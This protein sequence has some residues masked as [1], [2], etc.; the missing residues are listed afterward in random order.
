MSARCKGPATSRTREKDFVIDKPGLIRISAGGLVTFLHL[1]VQLPGDQR[2]KHE[3]L[4]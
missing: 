2:G 3:V 1:Q 4:R